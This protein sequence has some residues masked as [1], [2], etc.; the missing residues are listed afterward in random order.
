[1]SRIDG[2]NFDELRPVEIIPNINKFAEGSCLIRCGNTHVLCTASVEERI[3]PHVPYGEGW[4]TAEYSMLPRANRERSKRDIAKLKLSP[5]SAEIQRL[6]GR[7]LR[8]CVDMKKLGERTITIDC[9]VLQG[10]GGTRTASV[11]GGFVA[12][13]FA[14]WKLVQEGTIKEMPLKTCVAAVSAGIV[15]DQHH[16]IAGHPEGRHRRSVSMRAVLASHNKKKMKEMREILSQLGVEVVSQADVG[17]DLEPEE[18]GTTFEENARIKA[19]AIMEA[20]GLPAIADD[21]GLVVDALDGAPGVYSARYGG[22]GLDDTDRWKLLLKNMEGKTDRA[23]RFVSVICCVLPNGEEVM[24]RG[25]VH[26]VV[27]QGPSG[28][29]GFGYDPIFYLPERGC[30]MAQ[31]SAEEKNAISHRGNALRAFREEWE[32]RYGTDQ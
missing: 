7:A 30:T 24:S 25:E 9:D 11:T 6:I 32:R 15:A 10:D 17:V 20:T 29:G 16:G 5:R 18:T 26:G 8:A 28:D 27:A 19:A 21:S 4:V 31:L 14:C 2:R 22:E 12:L 3:P 13:S 23:C 1:M